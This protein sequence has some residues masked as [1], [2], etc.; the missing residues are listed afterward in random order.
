M[1]MGREANFGENSGHPSY[2]RFHPPDG[3]EGASTIA[4]VWVEGEIASDASPPSSS[5]IFQTYEADYFSLLF[6]KVRKV[7]GGGFIT[8]RER[9]GKRK[10]EYDWGKKGKCFKKE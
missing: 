5:F 8:S 9:E 3:P 7:G 1:R 10:Y 4:V 2:S 6:C